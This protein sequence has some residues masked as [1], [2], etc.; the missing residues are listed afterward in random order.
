MGTRLVNIVGIVKNFLE[1]KVGE[2]SRRINIMF[3][4]LGDFDLEVSYFG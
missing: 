4:F 3:F 1:V 2:V